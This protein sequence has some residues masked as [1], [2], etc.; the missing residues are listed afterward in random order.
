MPLKHI[1]IKLAFINHPHEV[2]LLCK[3]WERII[4]GMNAQNIYF[5]NV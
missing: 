1:M 2:Y 3:N 5:L 4:L